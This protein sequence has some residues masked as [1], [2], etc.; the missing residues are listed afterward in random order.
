[1]SADYFIAGQLDRNGERTDALA[2]EYARENNVDYAQAVKCVLK[3]AAE[4]HESK[5]TRAYEKA[6]SMR[7][8]GWTVYADANGIVEAE[9]KGGVAINRLSTLVSGLP[10]LPDHSIDAALAVRMINASF[11]DLARSAAGD[12]LSNVAMTAIRNRNMTPAEASSLHP[13]D[14]AVAAE[15]KNATVR[16]PEVAA[17]YNGA[18]VSEA[19]LRSMLW[20]LFG[21]TEQFAQRRTFDARGEVRRYEYTRER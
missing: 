11:S 13:H 21:K 18:S 14:T 10:R 17:I 6:G 4:Q 12:F 8:D 9:L 3:N 5:K 1:M 15:L 7:A 20:V 19:G 16:Y 2:R